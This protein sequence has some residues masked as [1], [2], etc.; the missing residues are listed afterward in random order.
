MKKGKKKMKRVLLFLAVLMGSTAWVAAQR[1]A[2][3]GDGN[4]IHVVMKQKNGYG[5]NVCYDFLFTSKPTM[6]Y[7][8]EYEDYELTIRDI[9]LTATDAKQKYGVDEI[10]LHQ[11]D[12][13][14]VSILGRPTGIDDITGDNI[15][16]ALS[17]DGR[18][19]D[20]GGLQSGEW[21]MLYTIDG[22]LLAKVQATNGK[23]A[24]ELPAAKAGTI[25][26]V[27]CGSGSFKLRVR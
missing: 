5:Q 27:K 17:G 1:P 13:E 9:I 10:V 25:Y 14:S 7:V 20:I 21:A 11:D 3:S 2:A 12:V 15:G 4:G 18:L 19:I 16:I 8:N 23:A 22:R 6:T 24:L 26:V